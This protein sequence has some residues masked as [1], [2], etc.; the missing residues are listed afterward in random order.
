[1]GLS[2][3]ASMKDA[4]KKPEAYCRRSRISDAAGFMLPQERTRQ[5]NWDTVL[6]SVFDRQGEGTEF[7]NNQGCFWAREVLWIISNTKVED[8]LLSKWISSALLLIPIA[9]LGHIIGLKVHVY[10]LQN[11]QTFRRVIGG[12]L[13]VICSIGLGA[14]R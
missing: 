2:R 12:V 1:M 5:N 11:D 8:F 6:G 14:L 4:R 9:G 10:L 7:N 13:F 3:S